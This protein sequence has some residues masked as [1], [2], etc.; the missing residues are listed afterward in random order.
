MHVNYRDALQYI[1][2][3]SKPFKL[4]RPLVAGSWCAGFGGCTLQPARTTDD[5]A[6]E[7]SD[8]PFKG[9]HTVKGIRTEF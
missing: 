8:I 7:S 3:L 4:I 2:G 6:T 1:R 5:F 9:L